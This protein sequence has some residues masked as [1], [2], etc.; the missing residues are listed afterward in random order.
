MARRGFSAAAL[1][2]F[3]MLALASCGPGALPILDQQSAGKATATARTFA[4]VSCLGPEIEGKYVGFT[5][6]NN[7]RF[8]S[9]VGW[10]VNEIAAQTVRDALVAIS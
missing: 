4:V 9:P 2:V 7:R 10:P 3:A 8:H 5:A 1:G 6:F